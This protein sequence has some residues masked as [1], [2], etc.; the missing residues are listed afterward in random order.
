MAE[1]YQIV[2]QPEAYDGM[3]S[4]YAYLEQNAPESA[5]G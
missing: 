3:E 2:I 5:Q 4:G 1:E